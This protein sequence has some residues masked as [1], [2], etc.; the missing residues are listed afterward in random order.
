MAAAQVRPRLTWH[1]L[2]ADQHLRFA[3]ATTTDAD[4]TSALN[5]WAIGVKAESKAFVLLRSDLGLPPPS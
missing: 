5:V 3:C 1:P 4:L 2:A